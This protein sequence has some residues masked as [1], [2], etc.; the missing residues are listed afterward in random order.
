MLGI[1]VCRMDIILVITLVSG[2]E[3]QNYC[4][5]FLSNVGPTFHQ[6]LA[7]VHL[8]HIP[9]WLIQKFHD[10]LWQVVRLLAPEMGCE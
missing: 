3:I 4:S 7:E 9:K 8:L 5:D 6:N 1:K 10:Q 2:T